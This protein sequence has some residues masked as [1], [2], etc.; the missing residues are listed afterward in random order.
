MR[1]SVCI[2]GAVAVIAAAVGIRRS[3]AARA[4]V[5]GAMPGRL[6]SWVNSYLNRPLYALM[7]DALDIRPEDNLLDVASGSGVFLADYASAAGQVAGID[8]CEPK[9]ELA[10]ERLHDRIAA[11]TAEVVAGDARSLPWEDDV[12]SAVTSMDAWGF[13]LLPDPAPVLSEMH[14]VLRSGGAPGRPSRLPRPREGP[15]GHGA[16]EAPPHFL[17]MDRACGAADVRGGRVQPDCRF[18]WLDGWRYAPL[19]PRCE[20][21]WVRRVQAGSCGQAVARAGRGRGPGSERARHRLTR[22]RRRKPRQVRS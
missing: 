17:D 21:S 4:I 19:R 11:G 9:V 6:G 14:R 8:L 5:P 13:V 10:R 16:R 20:T 22:L 12:F 1:R 3:R 15:K 7:A 2:A 18:V